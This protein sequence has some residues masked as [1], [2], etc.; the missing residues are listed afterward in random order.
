M[1]NLVGKVLGS[2]GAELVNAIGDQVNR[3][4]EL[5]ADITK[6]GMNNETSV[7]VAQTEVNKVE[8][9]SGNLFI[10]GWRP[11]CGWACVGGLV[12]QVMFRPIV[13][14]IMSN[15][16]HWSLPPELDINTLG[17]LLFGMLGL[18]AYRSA[19]KI[20]GTK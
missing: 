12:Y 11:A 15:I 3:K 20:K 1:A 5:Q 14:W 7:Q 8:A 13:G 18:G 16:F 17:T 19:E 6:T 10:A 4:A 9:G 2:A